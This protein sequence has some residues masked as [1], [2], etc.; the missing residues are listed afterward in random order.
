MRAGFGSRDSGIRATAAA[1]GRR[2]PQQE[3]QQ[4]DLRGADGDPDQA[5]A[6][7]RDVVG[8]AGQVRQQHVLLAG[9]RSAQPQA[10]D[11]AAGGL[12]HADERLVGGEGD[13]V[14]ETEPADHDRD[15]A[16]GVAADQPA[17]VRVGHEVATPLLEGEGE[18][19]VGEE[20]RA[21]RGHR[22]VVADP[23]RPASTS[24]TS[25]STAPSRGSRA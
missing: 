10:Y 2:Q 19:G 3:L 14:G 21:V 1:H 17:R 4:R 5:V 16:V 12:R 8:V 24:V 13:A 15:G 20:D 23:Q 9:T 25:G 7:A 6:A 18:G 11:V 22:G